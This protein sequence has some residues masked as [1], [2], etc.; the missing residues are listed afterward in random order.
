MVVGEESKPKARSA[1]ARAR[2]LSK[3][4]QTAAIMMHVRNAIKGA[5]YRQYKTQAEERLSEVTRMIDLDSDDNA[6]RES[7]FGAVLPTFILQAQHVA[8]VFAQQLDEDMVMWRHHSTWMN[9]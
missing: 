8:S 4:L 6:V 1:M 7:A 5:E 9:I 3:N 2:K